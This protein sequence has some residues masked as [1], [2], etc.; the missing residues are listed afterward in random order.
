M[1]GRFSGKSKKGEK[2]DS[3]KQ[4]VKEEPPLKETYAKPKILLVDIHENCAQAL[5]NAGYSVTSQTFG[6]VYKV[7]KSS[8]CVPVDISCINDY[9]EKDIVI[10]STFWPHKPVEYPEKNRGD[11]VWGIG[12]QCNSGIIDGRPYSMYYNADDFNK[13]H[14]RGVIFIVFL[15]GEYK[16]TYCRGHCYGNSFIADGRYDSI[17]YSNWS[18]LNHLSFIRSCEGSGDEINLTDQLPELSEILE[19]VIT[20][21]SY[22]G[23][24]EPNNYR[25]DNWVSIAK[26][27]YGEDVAGVIIGG[28]D[29]EDKRITLVLPG[30]PDNA[31]KIIVN[32]LERWFSLV[33]PDLFPHLETSRWIYSP[34][35]EIPKITGLK[36]KIEG[37][38]KQAEQNVKDIEKQI[39][40]ERTEGKDWYTLLQGT[41]D[42]LKESVIRVLKSIGFKDIRDIDKENPN[43]KRED[44]QIHDRTPILI[45]D[46]KGVQ[47]KPSDDESMQSEK[48]AIMRM[49]E[50]GK[51]PKEV[52]ALTI[53]NSEKNLPPDKRDQQAYRAAIIGNAKDKYVG[54][55]TTWDICRILR[56]KENLGWD[57]EKVKDIFYR[58]GRI[59]PIPTGYAEI[60]KIEIVWSDAFGV[61]P[62]CD[63]N[64][65]VKL[66][67]ETGI[68]FVEFTAE[69]IEVDKQPVEIAK[70]DIG[71]GIGY[72]N[73]DK[74][75][76]KG[77]R[78]F[79]VT[80]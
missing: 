25:K 70:K 31:D 13:L 69:S 53:I 22:S 16:V 28:P 8:D 65:G 43:E 68:M 45:V 59:E 55:M 58:I 62:N 51:N 39:E 7:K 37:I 11:K 71:L 63:F 74:I 48:H 18:F 36:E 42:E 67:V 26:N 10:V 52:Q 29:K 78:V 80:E 23:V 20:Q 75:F 57:I 32:L 35:Y 17:S 27:K 56:N 79:L 21:A 4:E 33:R 34:R 47:G 12:Q 66:A 38:K 77:M 19:P 60:G 72:K 9:Y 1:L 41:G 46:V 2:Q 54:L 5:S 73:S 61:I 64:K 30:I 50:W 49:R 24:I 14:S 40:Q 3:V 44:I 76:K 6:D 15:L